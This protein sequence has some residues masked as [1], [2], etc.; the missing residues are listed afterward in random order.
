[1][2]KRIDS[3]DLLKAFAIFLVVWGHVIQHCL[4][5]VYYEEPMYKLIYS[6]HMPLFMILA[7][8]FSHSSLQLPIN[9][10]ALKKLKELILPC[11]TW[12]G[13]IYGLLIVIHLLT[14]NNNPCSFGEFGKLLIHDYWF[15]KSLFICYLFAW[16][17]LSVKSKVLII[18]SVFLSQILSIYSIPIMYPCFICGYY[19]K[20]IID[21]PHFVKYRYVYL[22]LFIPL[23]IYTFFSNDFYDVTRETRLYDNGTLEGILNI[24]LYR[25]IKIIM[26][27]SGSLYLISM[28]RKYFW[29]VSEN[30]SHLARFTCSVGRKSMGIYLVHTVLVSYIMAGILKFDNMN[31]LLFNSIISPLLSIAIIIACMFAIHILEKNKVVRIIFL[32][33]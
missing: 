8:F 25:I 15:L 1:M 13:V 27:I 16:I 17:S 20:F 7:G 30:D 5:S 23:L 26:G 24:S 18:I 29:R 21:R 33:R 32:G 6:I 22:S 12:G 9:K 19:L 31:S 28:L 11:V 4:S 10:M 14:N 2:N 3:L